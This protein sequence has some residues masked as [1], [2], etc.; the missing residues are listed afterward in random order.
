MPHAVPKQ[1]FFG[2]QMAQI[3]RI[4]ADFQYKSVKR[5]YN[6]SLSANILKICVTRV[7]KKIR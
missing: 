5:Q 2:T 1:T 3:V 4:Y 7:L 6:N